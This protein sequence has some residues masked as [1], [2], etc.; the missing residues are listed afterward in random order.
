MFRNPFLWDKDRYKRS[1]DLLGTYRNNTALFIEKMTGLSKER[2]Q[3]IVLKE[4]SEGGRF[5]ARSPRVLSLTRKTEGNREKEVIT[6]DEFL[7]DI[8]TKRRVVS[9]SLAVY[10]H[11]KQKKS[12]LATY[13]VANVKK[14]GI[15][16]KAMFAAKM[17]K[18]IILERIRDGEQSSHKIN[19][20]A[21]SGAHNSKFTALWLRSAHS[22]LTSTCRTAAAYANANN[23]K[24]IGG[25][26]HYYSLDIIQESVISIISLAP[27]EAIEAVMRKYTIHVPTPEECIDVVLNSAK[28][29]GIER[30]HLGLTYELFHRLSDVERAAFVYVQDMH[31]LR[32]YNEELMRTIIDDFV[33]VPDDGIENPAEVMSKIDSDMFAFVSSLCGFLVQGKDMKEVAKHEPE[34]YAR[35]AHTAKKS[36]DVLTKYFDLIQALWATPCVPTSVAVFTAATRTLGVVSDTDSTIF[37]V[38]DWCFW[39]CG[40]R[41][42]NRE[43]S[44]VRNTMIYFAS[45]SIVHVLAM[46]SA[47]MGVAEEQLHQLAMKNEYAFPVFGLTSR[48]KH[49]F[50]YITEREGNVYDEPDLE[51]KGVEMRNSKVPKEINDLTKEFVTSAMDTIMEGGV[52]EIL[53]RIKMIADL[54]RRIMAETKAGSFKYLN[55]AR[56]NTSDAYTDDEV[57]SPFRFYN[58]WQEVF[59]PKYG[60]APPPPYDAIKISID[61]GKKSDLQRY[62]DSIEDRALAQRFANWMQA[63][64][65]TALTTVLV[66]RN[67]LILKGVPPELI[68]GM[69]M[70]KTVYGCVSTFYLEM[71]SFGFFMHNDKLTQLFSDQY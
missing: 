34:V 33:S 12:L 55:S 26:R 11:P 68:Q 15:A 36:Q 32:M 57:T 50:A 41:K 43:S 6:F 49:Y 47:N 45:Q 61:A 3:E 30:K 22:S 66:P 58:L 39:H 65:K 14:R 40:H 23:E 38:Q 37:T 7:H 42:I 20:N 27:L 1:L 19:N 60:E 64:G 21:L 17:A 28:Y 71:E 69:N 18:N 51:M 44:A 10:F 48:A 46:M 25:N 56:V 5:P 13:V 52:I 24:L 8:R 62:F 9:P 59:A 67:N 35:V 53:P 70:R 29:Y 63:N 31:Q 2:A 54:E 4:T 16:K